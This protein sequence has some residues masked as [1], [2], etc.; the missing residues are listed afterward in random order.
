MLYLQVI[1]GSVR[2][3]HTSKLAA[4]D[5]LRDYVQERLA[6]SIANADGGLVPGPDVRWIGRRHGRRQ[7][8]ALGEIVE[9]GADRE[10]APD[11]VP[12]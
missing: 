4:N 5:A 7:D 8:R 3:R 12:R 10:P 2:A 9:S 1:R 11:R 6:G